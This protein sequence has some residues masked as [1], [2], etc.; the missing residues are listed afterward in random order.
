MFCLPYAGGGASI[1]RYWS[2]LLTADVEVCA[3][4]LPGRDRR[5]N[6]PAVKRMSELVELLARQIIP[7]LD[8]PYVLFGHSLGALMAF[9]LARE[10]RRH[11]ALSPSALLVSGSPAPQLLK[12]E[13]AVAALPDVDF[14]S[15]LGLLTATPKAVLEDCELLELILPRM[16]AD[17]SVLETYTFCEEP[18]FTFTIGVFGGS[19]DHKV[20]FAALQAWGEHST[21]KAHITIVSGDHY[22]INGQKR[23]FIAALDA[24]LQSCIRR[25]TQQISVTGS[26]WKDDNRSFGNT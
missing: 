13:T 25:T 26:R 2:D 11:N 5:I 4:Q 7:F 6:E 22:F 1:F 10:L 18:P 15:K 20:P 9:E 16:R 17:F 8:R 19:E 14:V 3:V 12:I 23:Q 24:C 21:G